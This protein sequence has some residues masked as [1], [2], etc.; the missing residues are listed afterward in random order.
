[1]SKTLYPSSLRLTFL[2]LTAL[3]NSGSALGHSPSAA[4][5]DPLTVSRAKRTMSVRSDIT[6]TTTHS[7]EIVYKYRW[8]C[9]N[10]SCGKM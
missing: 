3:S 8:Q 7:Y 10:S 1:M 4:F 9:L 6:I 5:A 2:A